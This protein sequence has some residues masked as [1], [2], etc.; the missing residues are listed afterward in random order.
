[1]LHSLALGKGMQT[2]EIILN[3]RFHTASADCRTGVEPLSGIGN[4]KVS[5]ADIDFRWPILLLRFIGTASIADC[6]PHAIPAVRYKNKS[7]IRLKCPN[8]IIQTLV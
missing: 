8:L 5:P 7:L 1:M 6:L 3:L 2:P 4:T